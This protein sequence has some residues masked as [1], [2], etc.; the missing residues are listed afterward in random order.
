[1]QRTI[2]A[3][4]DATRARVFALERTDEVGGMRESFS[5]RTDLV[6]PARHHRDARVD[7]LDAEF[8]R[9]A[10]GAIEQALR[11]TGARR[12]IVCASPR[13]LG[14]LRSTDLRHDG[15]V[16]DEIARDYVKMTPPQI[17]DQLV[18]RGLV[19]TSPRREAS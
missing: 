6:N 3:V 16:T 18:A 10:A 7:E 5:E 1:M 9:A 11:D 14:F 17:H 13:M 2:I 12:V 19:P 15:V 8:A 4:V